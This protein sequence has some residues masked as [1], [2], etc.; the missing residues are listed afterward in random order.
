MRGEFKSGIEGD[1]SLNKK[2]N[3][4]GL[5]IGKEKETKKEELIRVIKNTKREIAENKELNE[6]AKNKL[7]ELVEKNEIELNEMEAK[8]AEK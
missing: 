6:E 5:D 7:E 3:P 1:E 4:L 8:E 2:E